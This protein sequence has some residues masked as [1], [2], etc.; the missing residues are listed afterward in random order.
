MKNKTGIMLNQAFIVVVASYALLFDYGCGDKFLSA[1][2]A[3]SGLNLF[4]IYQLQRDID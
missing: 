4:L 3:A 2:V 1:I